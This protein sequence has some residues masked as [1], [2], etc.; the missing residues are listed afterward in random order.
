MTTTEKRALIEQA[1]A[2]AVRDL[3]LAWVMHRL[4]CNSHF[5]YLVCEE[6]VVV[7]F[8]NTDRTRQIFETLNSGGAMEI[9]DPVSLV[10]GYFDFRKRVFEV[11]DG[12][13]TATRGDYHD[14]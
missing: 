10:K 6:V 2:I 11:K 14:D 4:G 13:L 7:V 12:H 8:D 9:E 1:D 5:D 3:P